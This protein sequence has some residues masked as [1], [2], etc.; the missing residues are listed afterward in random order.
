MAK[1]IYLSP[2]NQSANAFVVG[3][4]NEGAVWNDISVRLQKL[5][6][7]Y[8]CE[9]KMAKVSSN[10]TTRAAEAK[11]WGADVYIALHSNAA[12]SANKGAHG[13]E[14]YYDPKKGATTKALASD[15]L[16]ELS[17]M[18][19]SRGLRTS[20]TLIDCYKPTMPSV[21]GEC[22]FHDNKSDAQLILD[23]KDKIA[24]LYCNALVKNLGL[25]KKS[26]PKPE[27]A[28]DPKPTPAPA[29]EP[30]ADYITYTVV[31]GDTLSKIASRYGTTYQELAKLNGILN[32]NVI[33][34]GQKLKIPKTQK[35]ET[36][37]KGDI[38]AVTGT[39]YYTGAK[40]PD[41]VKK[42]NWIV[43]S[44]PAKS[45]RIVI[46]Y[47]VDHS[48]AIMSPVRRSDLKLIKKG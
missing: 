11:D 1:K 23:N 16:A 38:V 41:W 39:K 27:P 5:L 43:Y 2:S 19:T 35:A 7:D 21:I 17:T 4:T 14:V 20:S 9:T 47:S 15:I 46:H 10:L 8:D 25:K 31:K 45:D 3:G 22:G 13:V 30:S 42:L 26:E 29:P 40:I 36:I 24:Q 32:P 6:G 28:P 18:F 44:A 33:N 12:G 37:E 34:V 48:K